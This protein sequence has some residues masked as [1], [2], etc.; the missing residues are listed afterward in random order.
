MQQNML[1]GN[2]TLIIVVLKP[3]DKNYVTRG[4][5]FSGSN[6]RLRLRVNWSSSRKTTTT[7]TVTPRTPNFP[8]LEHKYPPL[9]ILGGCWHTLKLRTLNRQTAQ[10]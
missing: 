4:F 2:L 1:P 3:L 6:S 10:D 9:G 8:L 5:G 7:N